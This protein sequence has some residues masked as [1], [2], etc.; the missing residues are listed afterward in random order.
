MCMWVIVGVLPRPPLRC[1]A[2]YSDG[3]LLADQPGQAGKPK[4]CAGNIGT[5]ITAE[6]LFYNVPTRRH[7]L[8]NPADELTRVVDVISRC[9]STKRV[10]RLRFVAIH[11]VGRRRAPT[12][13]VV[14][15]R[16]RTFCRYA[17]HNPRASLTLKKHG[18]AA[19]L[20]RTAATGS[21]VCCR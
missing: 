15:T 10:H 14:L 6:E 3:K 21:H 8:K 17:I 1:R 9:A 2:S 18:E 19:A 5:Q 7:A 4:A 20:V 11:G 13:S 16:K 12:T